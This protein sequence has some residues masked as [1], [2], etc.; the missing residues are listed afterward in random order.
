MEIYGSWCALYLSL[1]PLR[2][3]YTTGN[4]VVAPEQLNQKMNEKEV[5]AVKR[6]SPNAIKCNKK[7]SRAATE[8]VRRRLNIL[9]SAAPQPT[10][11]SRCLLCSYQSVCLCKC[12]RD[13]RSKAHS[14]NINLSKLVNNLWNLNINLPADGLTTFDARFAL[15]CVDVNSF[16]FFFSVFAHIMPLIAIARV[17]GSDYCRKLRLEWRQQP[18]TRETKKKNIHKSQERKKVASKQLRYSADKFALCWF[19]IWFCRRA[20]YFFRQPLA[21]KFQR[22]SD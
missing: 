15:I 19:R 17:R 3:R 7:C 6:L 2:F 10:A 4:A 20:R 13:L 12:W 8:R 9:N 18:A 22:S 1:H 11:I 5:R 14:L 16:W 21:K